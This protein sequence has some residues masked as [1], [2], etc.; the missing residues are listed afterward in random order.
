MFSGSLPRAAPAKDFREIH[1]A[2]TAAALETVDKPLL[3]CCYVL[4]VP[5]FGG[6]RFV[7]LP[8]SAQLQTA[9]DN[10]L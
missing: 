10:R 5:F 9:V 7:Q 8:S 4:F 2:L 1:L 3:H 6:N